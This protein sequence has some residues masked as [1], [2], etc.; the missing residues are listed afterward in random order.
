[1][2]GGV[3]LVGACLGVPIDHRSATAQGAKGA[4][5]PFNL[6]DQT[7]IDD[8]ARLFRQT[9]TGYCHGKDGGPSRAPKLRGQHLEPGYVYGRIMNGSPNGMPA[10][11]PGLSQENIWKLVA[12]V[13]SISNAEDK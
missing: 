8:G 1:M 4:E 12:Y 9:C 6:S 5:A 3:L 10:F 13:I 2:T 7:V 11:G